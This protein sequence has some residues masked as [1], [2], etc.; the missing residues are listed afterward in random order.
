[1]CI[2]VRGNQ[3]LQLARQLIS[4]ALNCVVTGINAGDPTDRAVVHWDL[5]R[6]SDV[7]ARGDGDGAGGD[8]ILAGDERGAPVTRTAY[9]CVIPSDDTGISAVLLDA[10]EPSVRRIC[11]T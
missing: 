5:R 10:P 9:V 2:R 8:V 4:A 1:M 6:A 11:S 7:S 3:N